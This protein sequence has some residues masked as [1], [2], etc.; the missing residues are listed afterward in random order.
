MG[1][2]KGFSK[3]TDFNGVL[4]FVRNRLSDENPTSMY[5][6][7]E[8]LQSKGSDVGAYIN[9]LI[10]THGAH[11]NDGFGTTIGGIELIL[12]VNT[13]GSTYVPWPVTTQIVVP[14]NASVILRGVKYGRGATSLR[15]DGTGSYMIHVE[16]GWKTCR[17]EGMRL[18]SGGIAY[19]TL[20]AGDV[21][22]RDCD[23]VSTKD[24]AIQTLGDSVID[25]LIDRCKWRDCSGGVAVKH[26]ASDLW[27][28]N[29]CS[30]VRSTN[31]EV[32]VNSSTVTIRDCDFEQR[33]N[34]LYPFIHYDTGSFN[35]VI[36]ACRFGNET[37]EARDAIVC[38]PLS[39]T[40][41][42]RIQNI[43]ISNCY[44]FGAAGDTKD[45]T[46]GRSFVRC[47]SPVTGLN[48][49]GTIV[50]SRG[51]LRVI[52]EDHVDAGIA[53]HGFHSARIELMNDFVTVGNYGGVGTEFVMG[54][55]AKQI[56]VIHDETTILASG[57]TG[58]W[59][60]TA[61]LDLNTENYYI[62]LSASAAGNARAGYFYTPPTTGTLIVQVEARAGTGDAM[63]FGFTG[64]H[65][66][67]RL[68]NSWRLYES[69]YP[70]D[71]PR[72]NVNHSMWLY[73]YVGN[74]VT[75]AS[76]GDTIQIKNVKVR[77]E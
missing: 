54:S 41:T 16:T 20:V 49:Y 59:T 18:V 52:Q 55:H 63:R 42:D 44:A 19:E 22:V 66:E 15:W 14:S 35:N 74:N 75:G 8:I 65:H 61:A 32:Y 76:Q 56:P 2:N 3:R 24:W 26:Q 71:A 48:I 69:S 28:I 31:A 53:A 4:N 9:D 23:F 30:G 73:I 33:G 11:K 12:D 77:V 38:G 39:G 72:A 46:K 13:S 47:S 45:E 70:A 67:T 68:T 62:T 27:T 36:D 64:T 50:R 58:S 21:I 34:S 37:D 7:K 1:F 57:S 51:F 17:V 6:R 60:T 43:T 5:I 40:S 10:N 25:V 29:D